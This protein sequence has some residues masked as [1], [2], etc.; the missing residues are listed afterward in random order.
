M[1]QNDDKN[2]I[3]IELMIFCCKN[4]Y[5]AVNSMIELLI[6]FTKNNNPYVNSVNFFSIFSPLF[7]TWKIGKDMR[8]R[9]CIGTFNA[10]HL[11]AGLREYAATRWVGY[12]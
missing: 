1:L 7:V 10:M 6:L 4:N 8:L 12:E 9:G 3:L 11:Q 5:T 2:I